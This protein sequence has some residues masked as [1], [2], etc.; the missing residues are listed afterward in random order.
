MAAAFADDAVWAAEDWRWDPHKMQATPAEPG[1]GSKSSGGKSARGSAAPDTGKLGCQVRL[2]LAPQGTALV[3]GMVASPA[4]FWR[5]RAWCA[6][7]VRWE[8]S[9]AP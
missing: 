6:S 4:R 9:G 1:A 8:L 3:G 2:W 7:L 5:G